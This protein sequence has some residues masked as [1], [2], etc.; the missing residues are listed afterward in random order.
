MQRVT[1]EGKDT[2]M[3]KTRA[4]MLGIAAIVALTSLPTAGFAAGPTEAE[5][6]AACSGDAMRFCFSMIPNKDRVA[7]CLK[8]HRQQL[9]ATCKALFDKY[10]PIPGP[11]AD[12]ASRSLTTGAP[13][14]GE[15]APTV[16][17]PAAPAEATPTVAQP[18]SPAETTP[19]VAQ[20]AAPAET[21]PTVAQPAS[22]AETARPLGETSAVIAPSTNEMPM[23]VGVRPCDIFDCSRLPAPIKKV[24]RNMPV[25]PMEVV[26]R[27]MPVR[28]MAKAMRHF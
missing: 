24:M 23:P 13:S 10:D 17:Q 6:R 22:P 2:A 8:G 14:A 7:G 19:T 27:N 20:P 4:G 28:A 26:M 18:A 5:G 1:T 16:A 15:K 11:T 12:S 25:P 21:A 9:S 3:Y